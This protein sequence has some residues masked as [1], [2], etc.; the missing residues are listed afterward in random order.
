MGVCV[1]V[2]GEFELLLLLLLLL[3]LEMS[4]GIA[5]SM[6]S[7]RGSCTPIYS[8]VIPSSHQ[9]FPWRLSLNSIHR[10]HVHVCSALQV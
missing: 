3:L 6:G 4:A 9:F 7:W 2:M 8:G 10:L 1:C 5:T